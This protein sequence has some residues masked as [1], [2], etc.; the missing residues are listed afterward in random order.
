MG[1]MWIMNW[2]SPRKKLPRNSPDEMLTDQGHQFEASA[3][4]T[5]NLWAEPYEQW[6]YQS[7]TKTLCLMISRW[8]CMNIPYLGKYAWQIPYFFWEIRGNLLVTSPKSR[9]LVRTCWLNVR[10]VCS[11]LGLYCIS[12]YYI[13][14][15]YI[16]SFHIILYYIMLK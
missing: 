2:S 1:N 9:E 4:L 16:I 12:L 7:G 10:T 15:H 13:T 6:T 3:N 11:S 5:N 14:L 8:R